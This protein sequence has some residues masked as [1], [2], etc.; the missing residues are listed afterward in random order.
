[1]WKTIFD[2]LKTNHQE[3]KYTFK[4]LLHFVKNLRPASW[5]SANYAK[6]RFEEML[7][8]LKS[9]EELSLALQK[10]IEE[11]CLANN[12][13]V[14]LTDIGVMGSKGFVVGLFERLSYKMLPPL[15][16]KNELRTTLNEIFYENDDFE[17]VWA[18]PDKLWIEFFQTLHLFENEKVKEYWENEMLNA[19]VVLSQRA[20]AL[21]LEPEIIAKLP[22]M[23]DLTS[24]FLT[25]SREITHF[26]ENYKNNPSYKSDN[27]EDY[28]H[29]L[30][31]IQQCEES[32]SRL[33]KGKK[34]YGVSLRITYFIL[35]LTQNIERLKTILFILQS[36]EKAEKYNRVVDL[37][38]EMVFAENKKYS[39]RKHFSDNL[40][41]LAY[42]VVEHTSKTGEHYITSNKKEYWKLFRYA[43]GG[44]F[45]VAFLCIFKARIS[46]QH[47]PPFWEAFFF[48]LNYSL[49]FIMIHIL[50]FTLATKQPAMTASTIA[51]TIG[52]WEEEN[53]NLHSRDKKIQEVAPI[54]ARL[55]RSQFISLVGNVMMVFP[56][57]YGLT[58]LYEYIFNDSVVPI[59]KSQKMIAEL[60]PFTSAA[61][62]HAAIAAI[63]LM[64][65]G[66]IAGYY[67]NKVVYDDIPERLRRY[68]WLRKVFPKRI[69]LKFVDYIEK[70]LGALAGNFYLGLFLGFMGNIGKILG[71]N[72]DIR[73]VTF[74]AGNFAL[75]LFTLKNDVSAEVISI[76]ILGILLIGLVNVSVSFGLSVVVALK[77]RNITFTETRKLV[78]FILKTFWKNPWQFFL[79][80]EK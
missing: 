65:S 26:V 8:H 16:P 9:E 44:G 11:I 31:M 49:G 79:P 19:I 1:M 40:G 80:F 61:L 12:P 58:W 50:H 23:D 29:I 63:F 75:A 64:T 3:K 56:V 27:E 39:V 46:I 30:V 62:P 25:L 54:I 78:L 13:L 57:A 71:L 69:F 21:G 6:D 18:I 28:K 37:L 7:N 67:D 36:P 72:L 2:E 32:I 42:K 34:Q 59:E 17:W 48:G 35:R 10:H 33:Q 41:Y 38:K 73:H 53:P 70:N 14:L 20:T 68:S 51:E 4:T 24:P 76:T 22:D 47:F 43:L 77:S 66:L 5:K 74:A 52:A 55:V 60:A 45:I 15:M